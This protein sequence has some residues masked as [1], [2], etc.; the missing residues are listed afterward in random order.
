M[1]DFE[2]DSL[3]CCIWFCHTLVNSMVLTRWLVVFHG[4]CL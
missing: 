4:V 3:T 2:A 1:K